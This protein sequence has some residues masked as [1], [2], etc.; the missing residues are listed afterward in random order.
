MNNPAQCV[1][2]VHPVKMSSNQIV[3]ILL[4]VFLCNL[5][6]S[7]GLICKGCLE[8]DDFTFDKVLAKF[9]TV[10]VKFDIAFP[11]GK[12]HDEYA[13]FAQEMGDIDDMIVSVVGIKNYGNPTNND[14]ADRFEIEDQLPVV[15]LFI[16]HDKWIDFPKGD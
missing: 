2:K 14:L 5:S 13:A 3:L 7:N 8:L 12:K 15:K 1:L 6:I 4:G 11:Y 10:L 16:S 9:S